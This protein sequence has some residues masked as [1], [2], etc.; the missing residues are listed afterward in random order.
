[1]SSRR[2]SPVFRDK[3]ELYDF[4]NPYIEQYKEIPPLASNEDGEIINLTKYPKL[5]KIDDLNIQEKIQ[6]FYETSDL[7]HVLATFAK[8]QDPSLIFVKNDG[9][10]GDFSGFSH[11]SPQDIQEAHQRAKNAFDSLSKDEQD[12]VLAFLNNIKTAQKEKTET[13][14]EETKS[15][16][17]KS[18][19]GEK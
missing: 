3:V 19:G 1:M 16:E 10:Y 14:T 4:S 8:S 11:L 5:V 9:Q 6:S 2:N 18:E 17:T 13:K 12:A 7:Y 15:E